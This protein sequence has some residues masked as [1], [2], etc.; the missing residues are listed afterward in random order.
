VF[1]CSEKNTIICYINRVALSFHTH[2]H[3][4]VF[5]PP[6]KCSMSVPLST[7]GTLV[8]A[9]VKGQGK[10]Q[11]QGRENAEI[12]FVGNIPAYAPIIDHNVSIS[13]VPQ[14][15]DFLVFIS[16]SRL[17]YSNPSRLSFSLAWL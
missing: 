8:K 14:I 2:F 7:C 5:S 3:S 11:V 4:C 1:I 13:A 15:A 6:N 17:F 16:H 9:K 10:G 12:V